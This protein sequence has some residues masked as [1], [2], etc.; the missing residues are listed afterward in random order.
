MSSMAV[1]VA[2]LLTGASTGSLLEERLQHLEASHPVAEPAS[3]ELLAEILVNLSRDPCALD[4]EFE[5]RECRSALPRYR[6]R[7]QAFL[8]QAVF[9]IPLRVEEARYNF[10]TSK[11]RVVLVHEGL[12][13][14]SANALGRIGG[15]EFLFTREPKHGGCGLYFDFEQKVPF[16]TV[17]VSM[18]ADVARDAPIRSAPGEAKATAL[19]KVSRVAKTGG[20]EGCDQTYAVVSVLGTR[21]VDSGQAMVVETGP[22]R[23]TEG[24]RPNSAAR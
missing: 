5:E 12:D 17:E 21:V 11:L 24:P 16:Q 18:A 2:V 19:V 3:A 1:A 14:E 4:D 23:R 13:S 10:K 6:K 8:K 20:G 9:E 7:A 22:Y 15:E